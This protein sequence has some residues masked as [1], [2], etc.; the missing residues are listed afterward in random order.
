MFIIGDIIELIQDV[1]LTPRR[2]HYLDGDE[3]NNDP[4]NIIWMVK[5]EA[6]GR[7]PEDRLFRQ[8]EIA[9]VWKIDKGGTPQEHVWTRI[10]ADNHPVASYWATFKKI[11]KKTNKESENHDSLNEKNRDDRGERECFRQDC[12]GH[13][14]VATEGD[15]GRCFSC[16]MFYTFIPPLVIAKNIESSPRQH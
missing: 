12:K 14:A 15:K 16:G 11:D 2:R 7:R 1:D 6:E 10:L 8:G 9:R 13:V 4:D 5:T 3:K